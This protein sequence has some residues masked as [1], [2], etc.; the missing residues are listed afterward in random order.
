MLVQEAA[1]CY[2]P[3]MTPNK[4]GKASRSKDRNTRYATHVPVLKACIDVLSASVESPIYAIEHGMGLG[5]TPFF[6]SLSNVA[7]IISFEREQEWLFCNDC[8][9]GS[10]QPHSINL[11]SDKSAIEQA[12]T[13]I[14]EPSRTI[15]LVD[16]FAAQRAS[17]LEAWMSLGVAFI[18]EHDAE[19]FTERDVRHRRTLAKNFGYVAL[20]YAGRDPETA[21]FIKSG[22]KPKLDDCVD[23]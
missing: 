13:G 6:H 23:F 8:S 22:V 1:L 12:T 16:G 2:L 20:Q 10:L 18:V 15:A 4:R 11:L 19:V 9:S 7:N 17:V 3:Q 21:F 14:V 5:S